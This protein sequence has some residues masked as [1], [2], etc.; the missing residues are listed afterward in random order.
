MRMNRQSNFFSSQRRV[1]TGDLDETTTRSTPE[2]GKA[3]EEP[4]D[5]TM[6]EPDWA[7]VQETMAKSLAPMWYIY[8]Y[9][10]MYDPAILSF[11]FRRAN[12]TSA[13]FKKSLQRTKFIHD[14]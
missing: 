14:I 2:F 10:S 3:R 5:K 1:A 11:L 9:V 8:Q 7:H 6:R 13:I 4:V 12:G